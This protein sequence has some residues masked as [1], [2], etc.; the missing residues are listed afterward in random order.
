ME[1]TY[2]TLQGPAEGI[3]K[4]RGS[5]FLAFG[6]PVR[7]EEEIKGHVEKLKKKY[8]DARHHCFAWIL[9]PGKTR[10]R[11]FDD[12]EPAHSAGDAILGQLKKYDLTDVLMVVVRYFGG[13]KLG[14]GNLAGAYK[15]ATS[16]AL[17]QASIVRRELREDYLLE[18]P[19]RSTAEVMKLVKAF[20]LEIVEQ[21]FDDSCQVKVSVSLRDTDAFHKKI[22]LLHAV[23]VEVKV[24]K[25]NSGIGE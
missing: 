4:E 8:H 7:N 13:V 1:H 12:G 17:E 22:D 23:K 19:Y 9:G 10:Y 18:F 20:N 24:V 25:W 14:V 2:L 3:Y 11:A 6:F 16:N 15:T 21:H 5:R